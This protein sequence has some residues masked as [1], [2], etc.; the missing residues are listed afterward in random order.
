MIFTVFSWLKVSPKNHG[1]CFVSLNRKPVQIMKSFFT[2][3][4]HGGMVREIKIKSKM[5][6]AFYYKIFCSQKQKNNSSLLLF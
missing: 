1:R 3:F 4:V 6:K 5:R 2:V